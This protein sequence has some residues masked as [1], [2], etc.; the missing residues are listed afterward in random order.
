M[1]PYIEKNDGVPD[2]NRYSEALEAAKETVEA[3]N[4]LTDQALAQYTALVDS[5]VAGHIT[6]ERELEHIMD[7][8][9]DFGDD[10]RFLEI[11]KRLCRHI[12][13]K[14]PQM[15]GEHIYLWRMHGECSST[16]K[17]RRT[18]MNNL[19]S[20]LSNLKNACH[21]FRHYLRWP[22]PMY[23]PSQ[24][25]SFN[26]EHTCLASKLTNIELSDI[27]PLAKAGWIKAI[28][29]E[30]CFAERFS[31]LTKTFRAYQSGQHN[32]THNVAYQEV[33]FLDKVTLLYRESYTAEKLAWEHLNTWQWPYF[34]SCE[35]VE[36]E[37]LWLRCKDRYYRCFMAKFYSLKYGTDPNEQT[38]AG[39]MLWGF[40]EML[41]VDDLP[42][43]WN[44]LAE[45]EKNFK[46]LAEAQ[47]D[48]EAFR[49]APNPDFSE[50]CNDIFGDG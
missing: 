42:L 22:Y 45:P 20:K 23:K 37:H 3:L 16:P 9:L 7:G 36:S 44:R 30:K 32:I 34:M 6:D 39:G 27:C 24:F 49:A 35:K 29:V 15:V 13:Y 33:R 40:P 19:R 38:P 28:E 41:E 18:R 1:K 17:M 25:D 2:N 10:L 31:S 21:I 46:T 11:Y 14:H 48:W 26:H 43:M 12:F 47:A 50:F 8:L 5:A 4:K